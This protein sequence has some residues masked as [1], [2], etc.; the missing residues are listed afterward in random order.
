MAA[1]SVP[2]AK[3][4][5]RNE[6]A[7]FIDQAS[8]TAAVFDGLG[9][10]KEGAKASH[11]ASR[12][13]AGALRAYD[14]ELPSLQAEA[15]LYQAIRDAHDHLI[16][17]NNRGERAT[18]VTIAKIIEAKVFGNPE[19]VIAH[20]GDSRAYSFREGRLRYL[21]LDHSL[22][23]KDPEQARSVQTHLGEVTELT[24]L[25]D[26]ERKMFEK[27]HMLAAALGQA[28]RPPTVA[29]KTVKLKRGDQIILTTDGI[30]DNLTKSEIESVMLHAGSPDEAAKA[31]VHAAQDRSQELGHHI[32]AKRDDM[33]AVVL[34]C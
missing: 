15:V 2:S 19:A 13:I 28:E 30:H 6:D 29:L 26:L 10:E 21:T 14:R 12:F 25:S 27:R 8:G 17:Q 31:L 32:R 7:Y 24:G 16:S 1:E 20:V 22:L 9:G 33:T 23:L 11:E 34:A 18:T 5:E 3:H 4:P